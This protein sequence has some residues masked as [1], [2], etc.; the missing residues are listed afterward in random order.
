MHF[1]HAF[2]MFSIAFGLW[3]L[4]FAFTIEN[5]SLYHILHN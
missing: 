3:A 2:A 4:V 5:V 1:Q